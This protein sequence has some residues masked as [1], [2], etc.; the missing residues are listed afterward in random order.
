M[1][2]IEEVILPTAK[3]RF[4]SEQLQNLNYIFLKRLQEKHVQLN[5]EN[6]FMLSKFLTFM[7][8][9]SYNV[10]MLLSY[11]NFNLLSTRLIS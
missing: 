9:E 8:I 7:V 5:G 4:C 10:L 6:N 3:L 11:L 1:C 2:K